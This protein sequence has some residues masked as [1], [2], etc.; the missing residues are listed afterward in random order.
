[1]FG[2]LMLFCFNYIVLL[3][4][5]VALYVLLNNVEVEYKLQD[6]SVYRNLVWIIG[7][8]TFITYISHVN[9]VYVGKVSVINKHNLNVFRECFQIVIYL[10]LEIS[11]FRVKKEQ[12]IKTIWKWHYPCNNVSNFKAAIHIGMTFWMLK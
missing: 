7:T 2:Y 5:T 11:P 9:N 12:L 1:M 10:I 4:L 6:S 8:K 3:A